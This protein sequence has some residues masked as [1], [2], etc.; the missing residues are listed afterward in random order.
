MSSQSPK[1]PSARQPA[2]PGAR[3]MIS[4]SPL[5]DRDDRDDHDGGGAGLKP[6]VR[7]QTFHSGSPVDKARADEDASDAFETNDNSDAEEGIATTRASIELDV[8]PI[9]LVT[10]TDR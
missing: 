3:R 6:P 4:D 8:L 10:L 7:A 9:E 2:R 5:H 1:S